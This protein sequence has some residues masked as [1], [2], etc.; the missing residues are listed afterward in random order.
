MNIIKNLIFISLMVCLVITKMVISSELNEESKVAFDESYKL[1]P[2]LIEEFVE[3]K[4]ITLRCNRSRG[5]AQHVIEQLEE[6]KFDINNNIKFHFIESAG[7]KNVVVIVDTKLF[8]FSIM[9]LLQEDDDTFL[10]WILKSGN[11]DLQAKDDH[12]KLNPLEKCYDVYAKLLKMPWHKK[13]RK[14]KS[15]VCDIIRK[16]VSAGATVEIIPKELCE[17]SPWASDSAT[18][19]NKILE[20]D[21]FL[22]D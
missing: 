8:H 9:F 10:N 17:R 20:K 22:D 4:T 14:N 21:K 3:H 19:L 18:I 15:D 5:Y 13:L 11:L 12:Y 7:P 2:D 1:L 6:M 16:L